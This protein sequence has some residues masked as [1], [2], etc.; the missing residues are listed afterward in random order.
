MTVQ[1]IQAAII[2]LGLFI[3]FFYIFCM[4]ARKGKDDE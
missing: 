2:G 4:I 1:E 3:M